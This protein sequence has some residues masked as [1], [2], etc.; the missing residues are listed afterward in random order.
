M[1]SSSSSSSSCKVSSCSLSSNCSSLSCLK[2][3]GRNECL[4]A[5]KF[6]DFNPTGAVFVNQIIPVPCCVEIDGMPH[7]KNRLNLKFQE[8]KPPFFVEIA[9]EAPCCSRDDSQDS[10]R[11]HCSNWSSSKSGKSSKSSKSH[12][13]SKGHC[14]RK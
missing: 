11:R 1:S 6:L 9:R 2:D 4:L 3:C 10:T 5:R 8:M 12:K 13:C 7:T 14:S